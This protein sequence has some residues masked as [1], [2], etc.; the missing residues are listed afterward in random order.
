MD[1]VKSKEAETRSHLS[2]AGESRSI[3]HEAVAVVFKDIAGELGD[4]K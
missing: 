1:I 2:I 4:W 3:D